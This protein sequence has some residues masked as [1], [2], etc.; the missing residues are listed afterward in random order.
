MDKFN[1]STSAELHVPRLL[2][3]CQNNK[4]T[5]NLLIIDVF[6]CP[7]EGWKKT[8]GDSSHRHKT[9]TA[10]RVTTRGIADLFHHL[11]IRS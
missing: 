4:P 10:V 1:S 7:I 2:I 11:Q 6:K 5:Q 8:Q 9:V 3:S